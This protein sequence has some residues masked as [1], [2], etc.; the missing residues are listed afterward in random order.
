MEKASISHRVPFL[1]LFKRQGLIMLNDILLDVA[2]A[3]EAV[4]KYK[5]HNFSS[6]N[7]KNFMQIPR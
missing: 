5:Y 3:F 2:L 4:L 6:L 7:L 1:F